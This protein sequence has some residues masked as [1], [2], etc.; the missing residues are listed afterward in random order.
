MEFKYVIASAKTPFMLGK[1]VHSIHEQKSELRRSFA[2]I[3]VFLQAS[4]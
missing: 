4:F 3:F 2:S 1:E